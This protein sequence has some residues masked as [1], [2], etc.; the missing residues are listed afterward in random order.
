MLPFA[1]P[2]PPEKKIGYWGIPTSTIDWCEENY[3]VSPYMAE[4]LNTVTNA[5]FIAVAIYA[6][7]QC[8]RNKQEKR[9]I[10][11]ACGFLLVGIGSWLF[12]MTL[13]YEYQLL[14]ELPMLYA[15]CIPFWSAFSEF[16]DKKSSFYVGLYL[17][18]AVGTLT[19]IY[20]WFQDPTIHQV[21]YAVLCAGVIIRSVALAKKYVKDKKGYGQLNSL[22]V[23]GLSTFLLG[24][25]FWNLDVHYCT[26]ARSIRRSWGMPYGFLLEGHSWWHLF[27]GVGVYFY[28]VYMEQLR[29]WLSGC[30]DFYTLEWTYSILPVLKLTDPK[31]LETHRLNLKKEL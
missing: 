9:F 5:G 4:A 17:S 21:V 16:K 7:Y 13:K 1:V 28:L 15:T 14:D 24:Y 18:I 2:Y 19:C 27:T 31:G 22:M 3:V 23:I 30:Q 11:T 25:F 8:I 29:C 6:I 10:F 26:I 20:L 12:H